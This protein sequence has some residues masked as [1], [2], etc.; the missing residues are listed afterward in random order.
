MDYVNNINDALYIL[1]FVAI[2]ICFML[3]VITYVT[4]ID[5]EMK[6]NEDRILN[7]D[8]L[9]EQKEKH[10]ITYYSNET[11]DNVDF[12]VNVGGSIVKTETVYVE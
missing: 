12:K 11:K 9:N 2:I 6:M 4:G 3:L 1:I 7:S 5:R 8:I 10:T